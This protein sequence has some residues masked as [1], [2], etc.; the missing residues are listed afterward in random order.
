MILMLIFIFHSIWMF[1]D[2][3]AG[4]G[5]DIV[6]I[7]KFLFYYM[8]NLIP[9]IL[10][11]TVVLS[12]I[13]TFGTFAE[14]YEFAAMKASGISLKRAMR[15]LIIFMGFLSIAT[16][17]IANNVIPAAEQK[18]YSLRRNIAKVKPA[19]AIT[20][21]VF[22]NVGA[23][24][25]KVEDKYGENNRFL[26]DV[27]IHKN[28]PDRA[29]RT[30]IK[31]ANGELFS[32][33]D[34]NILQLILTDGHYYEDVK[35]NKIKDQEKYPH[36]KA[37]F[38]TYTMNID[39]SNMNDVD[40]NEVSS[41]NTFKMMNVNELVV[42]IDSIDSDTK[43]N[44]TA[45]GENMYRR[46]G[47]LSLAVPLT[48]AGKPIVKDSTKVLNYETDLLDF[49]DNYYKRQIIDIALNNNNG[50][51]YSIE[52]K[53]ADIQRRK[54]LLNHHIITLNDK[55]SLAVACIVLFFVGAPLGAIIRK[56]GMGLPLVIAMVLFLSYHFLGM[57]A[58][59]FAE[60]GSIH[61]IIGSWLSTLVMLPLGIFLT[62]RATADKG[63]FEFG[64]TL[65]SIFGFFKS[66]RGLFSKR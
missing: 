19:L 9:I 42:A 32:S 10:P 18:S 54:K 53:M 64:N 41:L 39:L 40:F 7:A 13:M 50:N 56:G 55:F 21:G 20:E 65:E 26:K 5:L 15:V 62:R 37:A 52:G 27:I 48:K 43:A 47:I 16:F 28:T 44:V 2:E 51:I 29:N 25:I 36:A 33:E 11:L 58:K 63:L 22:N 17:F 46:S 35:T 8:P 38:E 4:K 66:K 59:N 34:S 24:N 23:I 1:I 49:L 30:V 14:N 31:A 3:L 6:I 57:F 60:D 12:S 45:F 61:P